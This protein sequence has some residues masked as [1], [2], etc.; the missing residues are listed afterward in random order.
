M[1]TV[2][3]GPIG[4]IALRVHDIDAATTWYRDR[5]G[6][7]HL[8]SAPTAESDGAAGLS[9]FDCGGIRLMLGLPETEEQDH[10]G[11]ILYFTVPDIGAAHETLADRGVAFVERPTKVAD[12]GAS[13]LWLAF[14][15]DPWDNPLALMSEVPKAA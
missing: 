9:F 8:F 6:L 12:L 4:Q 14:F 7:P 3:L 13:E 15:R 2:T 1:E 11:A 10:P 5:L